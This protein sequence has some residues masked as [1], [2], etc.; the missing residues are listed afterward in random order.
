MV[1]SEEV[2]NELQKFSDYIEKYLPNIVK[3][4]GSF[5]F[6]DIFKNGGLLELY[7]KLR[8]TKIL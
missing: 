7:V 3:K 6:M 2:K 5:E 8:E 1:I 4:D